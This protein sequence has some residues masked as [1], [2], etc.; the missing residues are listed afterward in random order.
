MRRISRKNFIVII[1]VAV[2]VATT[3]FSLLIREFSVL[4]QPS[5]FFLLDIV[6]PKSSDKVLIISPHQDDE[7][8]AVG[9]YIQ[10]S[11][12]V[13][14]KVKIVL[15]T[16]GN[17]RK[18]GQDRDEEFFQATSKLGVKKDDLKFLDF[19][20]GQLKNT[21]KDKLSNS[22][23]S[24][25]INFSPTIIFY[26]DKSDRHSDHHVIG[27]VVES[28]ISN[29]T[30]IYAYSYLVHFKYFPQPIGLH[31]G[32][33]L[34]PPIKLIDFDHNWQKFSLSSDEENKK[35]EAISIYKSQLRTPILCNLILANVRKNELFS[36]KISPSSNSIK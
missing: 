6:E 2:L 24:E 17:R 12:E 4:P 9:G 35:Y 15:V 23:L 30:N 29:S 13:G 34:L 5:I 18:F 27:E 14:A 32:F 3:I 8:L 36:L 26:P 11:V 33:Y 31:H 19:P 1:I 20:D 21:P 22:I 7:T 28:L 16:D 25:M 10:R